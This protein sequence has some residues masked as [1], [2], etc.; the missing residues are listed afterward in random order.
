MTDLSNKLRALPD[1]EPPVGGWTRLQQRLERPARARP[2]L[3]AFALAASVALAV[4]LAVLMP[5]PP[6]QGQPPPGQPAQRSVGIEQLMQRSRQ[7]EAELAAVRSD[8]PVWDGRLAARTAALESGLQLVDLQLS[9]SEPERSP[10]QARRLWSDRVR[11]M[12]ALVQTHERAVLT[13]A[14]TAQSP[15][16]PASSASSENLL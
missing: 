12:D 15:D 7:L 6:R 3:P 13:P 10:E 5:T 9:Y 2:S 1:F 14:R 11:L 8:V 4:G 16:P